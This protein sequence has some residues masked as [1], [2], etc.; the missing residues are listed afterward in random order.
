MYVNIIYDL[1]KS[2]YVELKCWAIIWE[3]GKIRLY[4]IGT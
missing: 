2:N 4:Q 1:K 3:N